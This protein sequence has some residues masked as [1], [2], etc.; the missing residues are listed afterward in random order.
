MQVQPN[1]PP[2][3]ISSKGQV[4]IP[5]PIRSRYG[6]RPGTYVTIASARPTEI[7]IK[8]KPTQRKQS[9]V[10]KY[11]GSMRDLL[12]STTQYLAEKKKEIELEDS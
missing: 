6:W 9:L 7:T 1:L 11:W 10:D 5:E 3:K 12:P 2:V 8:K 4:V